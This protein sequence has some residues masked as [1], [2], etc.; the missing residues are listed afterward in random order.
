M[1]LFAGLAA[2]CGSDKSTDHESVNNE[3]TSTASVEGVPVS[4]IPATFEGLDPCSLL[5]VDEAEKAA[6]L[7]SVGPPRR[8]A[9]TAQLG[10]MAGCVWNPPND[11]GVGVS[12]TRPA[13]TPSAKQDKTWSDEI[14]HPAQARVISGACHASAWF[15]N[16]RMVELTISPPDRGR[17]ES[18]DD[19]V[20]ERSK[21]VIKELFAKIP[22]Q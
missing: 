14:G 15:S 5:T 11:V 13:M 1:A 10:E 21:P 6:G 18:S 22:W 2:G 16:D 17:S 19:S 20:C 3:S 9:A 8:E 12:F 4:A 7:S